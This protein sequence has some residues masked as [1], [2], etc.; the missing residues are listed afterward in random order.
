[1][2]NKSTYLMLLQ[3]LLSHRVYVCGIKL[4]IYF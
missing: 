4:Y 2:L 3:E 1:M